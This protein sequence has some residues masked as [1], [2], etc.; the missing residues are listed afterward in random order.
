MESYL[1][2]QNLPFP[3][4]SKHFV[5]TTQDTAPRASDSEWWHLYLSPAC[6][7]PFRCSNSGLKFVSATSSG[8]F[9]L[10]HRT[11]AESISTIIAMAPSR[12]AAS[13]SRKKLLTVFATTIELYHWR[14]KV[15]CIWIGQG[16]RYY[17]RC[18]RRL[19]KGITLAWKYFEMALWIFNSSGFDNSN[20]RNTTIVTEHIHIYIKKIGH[21]V[22]R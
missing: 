18:T 17:V 19:D 2:R 10:S 5:I 11:A 6:N 13:T 15:Y 16:A 8:S 12:R 9:G 20:I 21:H 7:N 22:G 4:N 3:S 1:C 14:S